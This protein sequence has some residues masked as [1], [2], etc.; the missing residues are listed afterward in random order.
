MTRI[1]P[2]GVPPDARDALAIAAEAALAGGRA[3]LRFYESDGLRIDEKRPGDPVTEADH[4]SNDAILAVLARR[5][6]EVRVLSEESDPPPDAGPVARAG[7][8]WVVDPLDGTKEFIARNG[9][10]SVMVGLCRDGRAE[11]GA[12]FQPGVD[13]LFLGVAGGGAWA[14]D[15]ASAAGGPAGAGSARPLRVP[16]D[17]DGRLRFVQ[18]RSH[19]DERITALQRALGDVEVVRSGSVGIKCA[20]I[21]A[22]RADLY[23]H[24]VKHLKEWDTCA[25][26][27]VLRG[28]GGRVTDCA[29]E[30]LSY[31]KADP[32]QMGGIFAARAGVWVRALPA[33]REVAAPLF[34]GGA[35]GP[36]EGDAR[37]GG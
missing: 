30:T 16:A 12:V 11:L 18:S 9:E 26:E 17:A 1:L 28:A 25:P 6:A 31:G 22:G 33:V 24:P 14:V 34:R 32:R 7:G 20:L 23:V 29:G 37:P 36:A 21:A 19:P 15:D 8:M 3:A 13:R 27:A 35:E 2:D 4:A 10:F 5:S